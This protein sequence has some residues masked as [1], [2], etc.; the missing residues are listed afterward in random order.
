MNQ[1]VFIENNKVSGSNPDGG[2]G[3][4]NEKKLKKLFF[5]TKKVVI[6]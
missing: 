4:N 2:I 3:Y 6:I 5:F 1:I